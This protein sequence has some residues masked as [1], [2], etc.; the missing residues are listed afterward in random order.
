MNRLRRFMLN[1]MLMAAVSVL[2]RAVA[3]AF[4]VY[5]SNKIGAVAMG[6]FSLITTVY[7]FGIT[8]ATSGINLA[9]TRLVAQVIGDDGKISLVNDNQKQAK[10]KLVLRQ[11]I[12]Y[13][14][15]FGALATVILLISAENI[16][17]YV[18]RDERTISSLR[19]LALTFI[20]ISLCS[21]LTGYFSAL[22]RVYKTALTQIMGQGAKIFAS[23]FFFSYIGASSVENACLCVVWGGAVA[24]FLSFALSYIFYLSDRKSSTI[25]IDDN[26]KQRSFKYLL[27]NAL[28]LA[29]SAYMRSALVTIEHVLIPIGLQKSGSSRD[30]SLAAYGTVS[31]MVFPLVLFP[32]AITASFAGLLIPE[33]AGS[34]EVGD[35]RRICGI[36]SSVMDTVLMFSIGCAGIMISFS[37]ELAAHIYPDSADA[38]RFIAMISPLI[39]VMYLD[40]AVDSMLKGLGEHVYSMV[41]N[42]ADAL[43]SVVLVWVLLPRLGIYGYIVTV[44]FTELI[45]AALSIAR[46]L[47]KSGVKPRVLLWVARPIFCVITATRLAHWLFDTMLIS[48]VYVQIL[49]A[50]ILYALLLILFGGIN[51]RKVSG[52]LRY[53]RLTK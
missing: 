40:T 4:N 43:I 45:N 49:I 15:F 27:S 51:L 22:R 34:Y 13:S 37:Y 10:I 33:I 7:G 46:L 44:Y 47:M 30:S 14:L 23:I 41:V 42:I 52:S 21:V 8:L 29:L 36:I 2:L 35:N 20:P 26:E 19:V 11:C 25:I 50:A 17:V 1:G 24:E 16:G 28:P 6:L 3:V 5:V 18:L 31:S 12:Y 39:P 32:S 53:M 48:G 38:G 9:T